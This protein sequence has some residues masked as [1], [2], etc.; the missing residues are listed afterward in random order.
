MRISIKCSWPQLWA[1][2]LEGTQSWQ[3]FPC[4][5]QLLM[6][7]RIHE[8]YFRSFTRLLWKP[9]FHPEWK[10]KN[11]FI[12]CSC[13][14]CLYLQGLEMGSTFLFRSG[15]G[16]SRA[17]S[18]RVAP[19]RWWALAFSQTEIWFC[20][21]TATMKT[22]PARPRRNIK[23]CSRQQKKTSNPQLCTCSFNHHS[24]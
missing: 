19:C 23:V 14:A 12:G 6:L 10:K 15:S 21:Q 1:A 13:A 24:A 3:C 2:I 16:T 7:S 4:S 11:P 22:D 9:A 18:A 17:S 5:C 8:P 20:A